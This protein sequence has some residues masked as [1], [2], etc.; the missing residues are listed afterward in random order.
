M[1]NLSIR[2]NILQVLAGSSS[3]TPVLLTSLKSLVAPGVK[4]AELNT[5]LDS[6][7][8]D[9]E[10]M[11]CSGFKDGKEYV[12]YWIPGNIPHKSPPLY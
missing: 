5:I 4:S 12:C 6:M 10:L 2:E 1:T 11:T 7:C 9:R 3:Q 8:Q